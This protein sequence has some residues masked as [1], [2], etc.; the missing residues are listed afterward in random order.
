MLPL[1]MEPAPLPVQA[2]SA[3]VVDFG[4]EAVLSREFLWEGLLSRLTACSGSPALA[5]SVCA[6]LRI[7]ASCMP[8]DLAHELRRAGITLDVLLRHL[9]IR[10]QLGYSKSAHQCMPVSPASNGA[11][12][13]TAQ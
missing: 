8:E 12:H 9:D 7:R 3:G 4:R 13:C 10:Q 5:C 2:A 11:Q 6:L 1:N